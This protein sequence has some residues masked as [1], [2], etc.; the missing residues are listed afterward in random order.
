MRSKLSPIAGTTADIVTHQDY[1]GNPTTPA[2]AAGRMVTPLVMRDIYENMKEAGVPEGL[3]LS[4]LTMF[5]ERVSTYDTVPDAVRGL[6]AIVSKEEAKADRARMDQKPV[7]RGYG[8]RRRA[9]VADEAARLLKLSAGSPTAEREATK[10]VSEAEALIL[11]GRA[12]RISR[13]M[14]D[15]APVSE[16]ITPADIQTADDLRFAYGEV[17]HEVAERAMDDK[18]MERHE[19]MN[20]LHP[21]RER[22]K[23]LGLAD[24]EQEKRAMAAVRRQFSALFYEALKDN[25]ADA[26]RRYVRARRALGVPGEGGGNQQPS[27]MTL[28][29]KHIESLRKEGE[30]DEEIARIKQIARDALQDR[31]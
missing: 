11:R 21:F 13:A 1:L 8:E 2:G 3:A 17:L 10:P 27:Q 14:L 12:E 29:L 4:V 24:E 20:A 19:K 28:L 31:R 16:A 9:H 7:R 15:G 25:D 26:A 18:P 22:A 5:G 6:N 23:E 30:S